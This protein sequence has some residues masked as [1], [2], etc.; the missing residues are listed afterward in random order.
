MCCCVLRLDRGLFRLFRYLFP[1][2][3]TKLLEKLDGWVQ[4]GRLAH[5][6][7]L[8]AVIIG[9]FNGVGVIWSEWIPESTG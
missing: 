8:E 6:N 5:F 7:S 4:V 9:V 1:H 3:D 2:V